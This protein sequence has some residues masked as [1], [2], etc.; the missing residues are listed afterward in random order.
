L[1][2][3]QFAE[4][5]LVDDPR[6]FR[7]IGLS[8]AATNE[9]EDALD[10]LS[11][12]LEAFPEDPLI[13]CR[14]GQAFHAAGRRQQAQACFEACLELSPS[15]EVAAWA[16]AGLEALRQV[17]ERQ[18]KRREA[19]GVPQD[20]Q[21]ADEDDFDPDIAPPEFRREQTQSRPMRE[22]VLRKSD[23]TAEYD[24][25]RHDRCP[26]CRSP[27]DKGAERCARCG[28]SMTAPPPGRAPSGGG[29]GGGGQCFIATAAC[30][31]ALAPAVVTLRA[32][33][34]SYLLT[35]PAG[36]WAVRLYE[37][38]S[39]P[40]AEALARHPRGCRLVRRALIVPLAT[41]VARREARAHG[42]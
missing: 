17:A 40:L 3:F 8:L 20:I 11:K 42:R 39:P 38:L 41:L 33:R 9:F 14:L 32:F 25:S 15:L 10:P 21:F 31:D 1:Q 23:D 26:V 6:V 36:R 37:L 4:A 16:N 7:G 28:G 30:G 13:A 29:G 18:T 27:N 22:R 35:R 19:A 2:E 24:P 5:V 34:D 12:A